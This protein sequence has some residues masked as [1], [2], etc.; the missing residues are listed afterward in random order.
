MSP[1]LVEL[2]VR[3]GRETDLVLR[4]AGRIPLSG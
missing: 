2:I 1:Q 4:R 3:L